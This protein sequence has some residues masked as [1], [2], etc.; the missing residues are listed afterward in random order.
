MN[1][2]VY[3]QQHGRADAGRSRTTCF[4]HIAADALTDSTQAGFTIVEVL[5]AVVVFA[6]GLVAA[7]A[8]Q[9]RAIEQS[10]FSDQ[11]TIR[12]NSVSHWAETLA[13]QPVRDEIVDIDGGSSLDVGVSD[14]FKD[15]N[16]CPYGTTCEWDYVEFDERQPQ[17][18]RQ[19]ITRGYPLPNLF[20]IELEALPRGVSD[21]MAERRAVRTAY[22][23]TTRW[24]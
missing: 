24:N 22:V 2:H 23:R 10:S 15:A 7:S 19:K 21:D 18:I 16:T 17:R 8:M 4:A 5:V 14:F 6:V 1:K 12:V 9:T 11:M 3:R 20:M 13:R